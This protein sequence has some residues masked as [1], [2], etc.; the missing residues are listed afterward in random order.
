MG[1]AL[2]GLK[3]TKRSLRA[4]LDEIDDG[5]KALVE[6]AGIKTARRAKANTDSTTIRGS[7]RH[8]H[9]RTDNSATSIVRAGVGL[10]MPELAAYKEWGT[11]TANVKIP[12]GLED[13]AMRWFVSGKG[14]MPPSPY[15]FPAFE[16]TKKEVAADL[17]KLA[18]TGKVPA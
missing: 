18:R 8:E 1:A 15:F 16:V 3:Q 13:Y 10:E 12:P 14:T 4:K 5:A 2:K 9:R 17:K 11:G 6:E 7:I